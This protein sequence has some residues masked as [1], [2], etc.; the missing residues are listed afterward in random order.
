MRAPAG[1]GMSV[2]CWA[3]VLS[4]VAP[5]VAL[6]D[7]AIGSEEEKRE[8]AERAAARKLAPVRAFAVESLVAKAFTGHV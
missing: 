7:G 8:Q 1:I 2:N 5:F 6:L 4:S 3:W